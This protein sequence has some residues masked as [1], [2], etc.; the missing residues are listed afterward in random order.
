[1]LKTVLFFW[2]FSMNNK[3]FFELNRDVF[4]KYYFQGKTHQEEAVIA[5]KDL[6]S[7]G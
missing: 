6:I 2:L 4:L 7:R 3:L 5:Y 1:M